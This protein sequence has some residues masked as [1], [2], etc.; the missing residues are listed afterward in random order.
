MLPSLSAIAQ[1]A[2][3]EEN[4]VK[5]GFVLN[6]AKYTTWPLRP[7]PSE[8][9]LCSLSNAPLDGA[10]S[11]LQGRTIHGTVLQVRS[12]LRPSDLRDCQM[13]FVGAQEAARVDFILAQLS[14][15]PILTVGDTPGFVQSGG[16]IGLKIANDRIRFD[17]NLAAARR[18]GLAVSANMA[19]L[20][21]EVLQ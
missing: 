17:V 19:K 6:F 10:L 14:N 3:A 1:G 11:V 8:L 7:L 20:A 16:M 18:A 21:D 12:S 5:A 13:I 2:I 15:L 9:K 4:R